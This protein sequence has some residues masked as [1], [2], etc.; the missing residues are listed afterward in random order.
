[1]NRG[2]KF[3]NKIYKCTIISKIKPIIILASCLVLS[4]IIESIKIIEI[5]ESTLERCLS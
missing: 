3:N 4:K 2:E 5:I 1:M